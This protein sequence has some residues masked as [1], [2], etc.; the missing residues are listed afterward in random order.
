MKYI[1]NQHCR[2]IDKSGYSNHGYFI[3]RTIFG[4]L[5]FEEQGTN[6]II[7]I[8]K[9][10]QTIESFYETKESRKLK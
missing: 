7:K 8:S 9:N 5:L 4:N 6:K 2:W 3:K 10:N 1:Y